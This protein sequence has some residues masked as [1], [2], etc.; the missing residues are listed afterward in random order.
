M[1]ASGVFGFDAQASCE[2][3]HTTDNDPPIDSDLKRN[4]ILF[5]NLPRTF[6]ARYV[7]RGEEPRSQFVNLCP[8]FLFKSESVPL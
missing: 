1:R 2:S 3:Y 7:Q 8:Q 5:E 6:S 4:L